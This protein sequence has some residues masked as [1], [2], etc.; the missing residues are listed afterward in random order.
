MTEVVLDSSAVLADLRGEPGAE[1]V[2]AAPPTSY[3]SA[4][5][6]AEIITKLIETGT[7]PDVAGQIAEELGYEVMVAD[8]ARAAAAGK[9]HAKTRRTGVSL[10]DRFCL[11][12]ALE[13]GVPALTGDRRWKALDLAVEITLIR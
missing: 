8:Q 2:R 1:V 5:N 13:L 9:L 4:V 12:L 10:G 3:L 7:P 6:L 11:A